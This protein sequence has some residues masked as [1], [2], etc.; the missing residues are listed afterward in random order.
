MKIFISIF[1]I[2]SLLLSSC[3]SKEEVDLLVINAKAYTVDADFTTAEAFAVTDGKIVDL[4]STSDLNS[5]YTAKETLD[6]EQKTILPGL[7]DAHA[8]LYNLG[9]KLSRVDLDGTVSYKDVISRV[10][11]FKKKFPETEYIIGGGWDQN[12]WAIKEFPTKDT[13]DLLFP[14]TPVALTRIDGHAMIVNQKALDKANIDES[15]PVFGGEIVQNNGKLTGILIDNPMAKIRVTFPELDK[16]AQI[17]ALKSAE[18]IAISLGLTSLVDAGLNSDVI[19]LIDDLQNAGELKMRIYAMIRNNKENIS[20]FL[21]SGILK[22]DRLNVRSVKVY[23]DG[24]LGSRGAALKEPYS[25]K[26]DHFGSMIIDLNDF[27]TLAARLYNSEFQMNTH[28]IGDSANSVVLKTY[29]SLLQ[30]DENRR[31]RVEHAQVMDDRDF[32]YFDGENIIPSVQPTH[33]TSDMYWAEDRLGEQRTG[34]A[35]AYKTLLDN[36]GKVALGTDFPIENVNPFLTFYA[37]VARQ[38]LENYPE[39]GFN[40]DEKLSREETLK[41]MTIWAAYANFEDQEKGSLEPGKFA[42]FILVDQDPM[43]VELNKIPA[44]KVL[45]TYIGGE[46]VYSLN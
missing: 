3:Q 22:T 30:N 25:D 4:G 28:A 17:T 26:E 40:P 9:L 46:K 23:A 39:G 32:K 19:H 38:D 24:A 12:D 13:L 36:A 42:D 33:A 15:T 2:A 21:E 43:K 10:Q 20:E 18:D 35:Y 7:I 29:D 16:A 34:F 14:D 45:S 44:T 6:A 41:G 1:S 37:A 27:K 8:H 5:K 11:E 31:W